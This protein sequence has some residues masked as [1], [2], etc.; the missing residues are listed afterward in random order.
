MIS[1]LAGYAY[2]HIAYYF[3]HD[4]QPL[5]NNLL[6][7]LHFNATIFLIENAHAHMYTA[8]ACKSSTYTITGSSQC[9]DQKAKANY[10]QLLNWNL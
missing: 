10:S 6:F 9:Q 5:P 3:S 8:Q 7:P 1:M 2:M 4:N